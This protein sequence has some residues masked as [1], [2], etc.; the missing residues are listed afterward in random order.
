MQPESVCANCG[1]ITSEPN[2]AMS[3]NIIH[4]LLI[5]LPSNI[6][7]KIHGSISLEKHAIFLHFLISI[8]FKDVG[9]ATASHFAP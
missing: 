5:L 2:G 1:Q 9:V 4:N 8:A 3:C 6:K 7:N